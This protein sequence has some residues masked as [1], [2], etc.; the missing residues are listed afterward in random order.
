MSSRSPNK[1]ISDLVKIVGLQYKKKYESMDDIKSLRYGKVMIMTGQDQDGS[2]IKGLVIN[3]IH[4]N[5]PGLLKLPFLEEF[6]TPIVKV[7]K[8]NQSQSFTRCQSFRSGKRQRMVST[9]GKSSTIRVWEPL[10]PKKPRSTSRTWRGTKIKFKYTGQHD[11]NAI[12]LAFSMK[13]I[14]ERKEWL[15]DWMEE[16]KRRKE[17]GMPQVYLYENDTKAVNYNDFV[18]KELVLFSNMD[19]ERSIPC[20]VDGF[21]PGQRKVFFTCLKRN[22]VKEVKVAQLAGSVSEKSA[23]QHGEASLLGTIIGLAQNY[24]GSNNINL[25]MPIGQFGTRLV[26][27]GVLPASRKAVLFT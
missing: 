11:D 27:S 1:E 5:W 8:G 4:H 26:L 22:L 18:N 16:G 2:H 14:K 21:K 10:P 6:I 24:V 19:N 13:K 20:L 7:T 9:L 15:T 17:L 23:Y 12:T 3:F 25:L